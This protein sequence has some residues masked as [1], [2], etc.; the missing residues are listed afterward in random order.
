VPSALTRA[1]HLLQAGHHRA[2]RLLPR[3]C[4]GT[5]SLI[6]AVSAIGLIGLAGLAAEAGVWYLEKRRGQNAADAAAMAGVLQLAGG[7]GGATTPSQAGVD[8]ALLNSYVSGTAGVTVTV[9]NPP[10]SGAYAAN[11]NAVEAIVSKSMTPL[12]S[13]LFLTGPVNISERAVG[14]LDANGQAC[15]LSLSGPITSWGSASIDAPSCIL[16]SNNTDSTASIDCLKTVT[17]AALVASGGIT[18][19][20]GVGTMR[21][22]QPHTADPFVAAQSVTMPPMAASPATCQNMPSLKGTATLDASY[23]YETGGKM[24][25]DASFGSGKNKTSF[26][27][28]MSLTGNPTVTLAPG[29]YIFYNASISLK[30]GTLQCPACSPGGAG[31]TIILT[32]SPAS[33]IGTI[34]GNGNVTITLNA[35]KISGFNAAFDGVLLYIDR[36]APEAS[37]TINGGASSVLTGGL[38]FPSQDLTFSGNASVGNAALSACIEIVAYSVTFTGNSAADLSSCGADGT[39]VAL[40]QS[41]HMV[42]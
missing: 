40:P 12:L 25:C 15:V 22:F 9:N 38:Y 8:A 36:N 1:D 7:A 42:E 41:V 28:D 14:L 32:G 27:G 18:S 2:V 16:A 4:R 37:V 31:V 6:F 10:Q 3:D 35:P 39:N 13:S 21:P 20:C 34:G 29:T 17:A 11:S 33:S 26:S 24:F 23:T 19:A 30:N 5:A